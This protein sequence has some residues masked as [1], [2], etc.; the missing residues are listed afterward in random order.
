VY[1]ELKNHRT[2]RVMLAIIQSNMAEENFISNMEKNVV[3][4]ETNMDSAC[5]RKTPS[6]LNIEILEG[7]RCL[8]VRLD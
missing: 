4:K 3:E 1:G 2:G 7:L 8:N 6:L 5:T